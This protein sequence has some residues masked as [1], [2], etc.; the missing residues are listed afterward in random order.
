MSPCH[1]KTGGGFAGVEGRGT[2][3]K[4]FDEAHLRSFLL[5]RFA[6]ELCLA[7]T[8]CIRLASELSLSLSRIFWLN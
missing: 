1:S 5:G 3:G 8:L 7:L 2:G 6:S 4:Y